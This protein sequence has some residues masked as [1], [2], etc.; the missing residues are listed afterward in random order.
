MHA[1]KAKPNPV[2]HTKNVFY[3]A[4]G[5]GRDSYIETTS[6]GQF[7]TLNATYCYKE[8][9]KKT[10]RGYDRETSKHR[11]PRPLS[12]TPVSC[13]P[14]MRRGVRKEKLLKS[15]ND[16]TNLKDEEKIDTSVFA[17][18]GAGSLSMKPRLFLK[19]VDVL[20]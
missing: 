2:I 1:I 12:S 8:N 10:L 17:N 20:T 4:N 5:T 16:L 3:R 13:N 7:S 15:I 11:V 18:Q 19:D 14:I 9:F 6:G